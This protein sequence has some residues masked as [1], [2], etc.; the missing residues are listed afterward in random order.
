MLRTV[1][2]AATAAQGP[3]TF[4]TVH[5]HAAN[6]RPAVAGRRQA[7]ENTAHEQYERKRVKTAIRR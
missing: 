2:A 4:Y 6:S 1:I 3:V 7:T 5:A